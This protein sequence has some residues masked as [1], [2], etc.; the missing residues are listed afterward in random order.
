MTL[1]E[2]KQMLRVGAVFIYADVDQAYFES[3]AY[4]NDMY[5]KPPK[6][7]K[8]RV[9]ICTSTNPVYGQYVNMVRLG[10]S[11]RDIKAGT[12]QVSIC[13]IEEVVEYLTAGMFR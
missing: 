1:K 2:A 4:I 10:E 7:Y 12:G 5:R 6:K 9:G 3:D 8:R 13:L 11:E